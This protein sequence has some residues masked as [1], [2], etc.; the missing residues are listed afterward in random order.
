MFALTFV[1]TFLS[2]F[3]TSRNYISQATSRKMFNSIGMWGQAILLLIISYTWKY[4]TLSMVILVLMIGV[5]C[6]VNVGFLI[7]YL[8]LSPNY[9]GLLMGIGTFG[10]NITSILGPLFVGYIVTDNVKNFLAIFSVFFN[11]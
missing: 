4:T 3:L 2:K 1:S 10:G 7:N 9:V 6:G 11:V 5:N 8:D